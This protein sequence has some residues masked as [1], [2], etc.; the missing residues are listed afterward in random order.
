LT[1]EQLVALELEHLHAKHDDLEKYIGLV[2][3]QDR[4]EK[5]FYRIFVENIS[6]LLP[7]VYTPRAARR[8]SDSATL[9]GIR[10]ES[11][12]RPTM[13]IACRTYSAMRHRPTSA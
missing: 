13:S 5:L 9:C 11:G 3:L 10:A 2:A 8:V 1:R 4:D 7:I 6:E 12:L